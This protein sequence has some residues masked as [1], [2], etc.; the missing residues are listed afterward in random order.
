MPEPTPKTDE[1]L[2]R[3]DEAK[4]RYF[5]SK[6]GKDAI[7]SYLNSDKGKD[8]TKKYRSS[9]KG[10]LALRRYYHSEKGQEAHQRHKGKVN[11]FKEIE[12]WLKANPGKTIEDYNAAHQ[13]END[14]GAG[15]A[16][17]TSPSPP[18]LDGKEEKEYSV[19]EYFQS[20]PEEVKKEIIGDS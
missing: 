11:R 16:V 2:A 12:K 5:K 8:A 20:L 3:T 10:K 1:E 17:K 14:P 9:T 7:R 18:K 19:E 4:K 6:K 13:G 15:I